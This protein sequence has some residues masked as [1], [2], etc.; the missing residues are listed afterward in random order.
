MFNEDNKTIC[1]V[2]SPSGVGA[3]AIIRLSGLKSV[4][5]AAKILNKPKKILT[6]DAGQMVFTTIVSENKKILDEVLMVKFLEPH[7]FTG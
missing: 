7:S 4:E 6:S 5:I 1:A 2:S 3:I